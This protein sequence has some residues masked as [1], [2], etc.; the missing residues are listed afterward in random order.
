MGEV[1]RR[2]KQ[3]ELGI[4]NP[5]DHDWADTPRA[6]FPPGAQKIY[7]E[8]V[9]SY[10]ANI[11]DGYLD[12]LSTADRETWLENLKKLSDEWEKEAIEASKPE[13]S[14]LDRDWWQKNW[15]VGTA[16]VGLA[17]IVVACIFSPGW[18]LFPVICLFLAL[19]GLAWDARSPGIAISCLVILVVEFLAIRLA[20]ANDSIS[21][22]AIGLFA[23]IG[24]PFVFTGLWLSLIPNDGYG[25][26][27]PESRKL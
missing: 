22:Y 21:V 2:R 1:R 5:T 3:S 16:S 10:F 8:R 4:P 27:S 24:F 20:I 14:I 17:I 11:P 9:D 25:V 15:Q 23:F 12:T 19:G 7:D 26:D 18:M 6:T 13:L